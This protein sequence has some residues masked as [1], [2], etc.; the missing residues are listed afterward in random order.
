MIW[1]C[2]FPQTEETFLEGTAGPM[3][4]AGLSKMSQ[5]CLVIPET[6]RTEKDP[7]ANLEEADS[8]MI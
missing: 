7:Q 8:G 4:G 1:K 5:G 3:S 6:Q 2:R